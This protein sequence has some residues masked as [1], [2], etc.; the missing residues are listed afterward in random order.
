MAVEMIDAG[1]GRATTDAVLRALATE[2]VTVKQLAAVEPARG[3]RRHRGWQ[4]DPV[5]FYMKVQ[6]II[7]CELTSL[8]AYLGRPLSTSDCATPAPYGQAG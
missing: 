5:A 4:Q 6:A 8:V 1:Y 7:I 2:L 3:D